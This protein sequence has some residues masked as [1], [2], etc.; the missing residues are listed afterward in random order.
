VGGGRFFIN[1]VDTRTQGVDVVVSW[2]VKTVGA[3]NFDFTV[4]GNFTD[5]KVTKTPV[6][7]QLAALNPAPVLFDRLNVLS[8]E[9]GQPENKISA[10]ANWKLG[11]WGATF[12]ATRYGKVL[13]PGTTAALDFWMSA[14]T[15]VDLEGRFEV[16]P[17]LSLALGADNLFDQYPETQ[18]PALN[19]TGNTP[20]ANYAPF[21]RG[22]RYIYA[23]MNYGF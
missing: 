14:R 8:L 11:Q 15:V 9:K 22:G 3:G 2:P 10:N 7:A 4:A 19:T 16:T 21:G 18:P 6:T 23:R 17:K 13:S 20:F 5:T 1:G 12:R